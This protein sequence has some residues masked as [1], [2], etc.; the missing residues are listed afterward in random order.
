MQKWRGISYLIGFR[1]R[2]TTKKAA[3]DS[4]QRSGA[5]SEA[6]RTDSDE[7]EVFPWNVNFATGFELIDQQHRHLVQLL[8]RQAGTL[9]DGDVSEVNGAFDDRRTDEPV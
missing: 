1:S 2:E 7:F 6:R 5:E 8:N 3:A 9:V 4:Q